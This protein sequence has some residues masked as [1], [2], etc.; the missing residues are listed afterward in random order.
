VPAGE[1]IDTLTDDAI[2]GEFPAGESIDTLTAGATAGEVPDGLSMATLIN[3]DVGVAIPVYPPNGAV[4]NTADSA[5]PADM[6]ATPS[7]I[8]S[9]PKLTEPVEGTDTY[10][11]EFTTEL[12]LFLRYILTPFATG[13]TTERSRDPDEPGVS[14][15]CE[16][17]ILSAEPDMV[18]PIFAEPYNV[19]T[20][21]V[22]EPA[23]VAV[24]SAVTL[25][26]VALTFS[27]TRSGLLEVTDPVVNR[28]IPEMF[29][30]I[31]E[32]LNTVSGL[33]EYNSG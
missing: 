28:F 11:G 1:S 24:M 20:V 10:S 29:T 13:G 25:V 21:I 5:M 12:S 3:S 9:K 26:S 19:V 6:R 15:V 14:A 33:I 2:T 27:I 7:W 16:G 22:A 4:T 30:N 8:V 17:L 23:D 31:L 18:T 32:P